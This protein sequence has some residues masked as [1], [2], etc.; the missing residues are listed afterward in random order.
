MVVPVAVMGVVVV[1]VVVWC[2]WW[3]GRSGCGGGCDSVC[4]GSICNSCM[5]AMV[6]VVVSVGLQ[7]LL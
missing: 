7:W 4:K 2:W 6:N 1:G 3:L 5:S